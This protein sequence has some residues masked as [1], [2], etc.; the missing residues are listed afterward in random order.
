[1]QNVLSQCQVKAYRRDGFV[2]P[3][4]VMSG[5]EAASLRD[6]LEEAERSYPEAVSAQ[7]RNNSHLVL[8]CVDEI[9]HQ[10]AILEA[11]EGLIGPNILAWGSVLF[12]KDPD[13]KS[14]VSWHQDL[15]YT[16][17]SP[18]DGVTAWLALTPSNR[19]NGCMQMMPGSHLGEI[20]THHDQFGDDNI[21]TRGQTNGDIDESKTV[22]IILRPG[23]ISLHHGR[24]IHSSAP[25]C[26]TERRIGVALQ[27]Y[28][29]THVQEMGARGFAQL[30]RGTDEHTHFHLLER[31]ASDLSAA[32]LAARQQNNDH[33]ASMLYKGAS[34]KRAY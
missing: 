34:R 26:S 31:P 13:A 25:N 28:L 16:P 27:Q 2:F 23:Q 1:M 6:R 11:V 14:F 21:L 7:N 19:H 12:I 3:V 30:A 4:D 24:T 10:P 15:T 5:V 20:H 17:L 29:P 9:V 22:D 33:W 32:A 8:K 18:H